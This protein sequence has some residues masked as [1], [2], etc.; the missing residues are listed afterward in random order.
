MGFAYWLN[1][2]LNFEVMAP[3]TEICHRNRGGSVKG[4][5]IDQDEPPPIMR[6]WKRIYAAIIVY[7]CAL[8]ILLYLMTIELNR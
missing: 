7:T 4:Q 2:L 1:R 5:K 3:V 8:I 6:T